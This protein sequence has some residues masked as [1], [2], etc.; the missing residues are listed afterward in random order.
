MLATSIYS[1]FTGTPDRG[2]R[3]KHQTPGWTNGKAAEE[4]KVNTYRALDQRKDFFNKTLEYEASS[5]LGNDC[6]HVRQETK[7]PCDQREQSP[8]EKWGAPQAKQRSRGGNPSGQHACGTGSSLPGEAA[9][10]PTA[11]CTWVW[12]TWARTFS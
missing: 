7:A 2:V 4:G 10:H 6:R 11:G 3:S 5:H 9:G 12:W 1:T 8:G